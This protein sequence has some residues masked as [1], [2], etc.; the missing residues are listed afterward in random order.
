LVNRPAKAKARAGAGWTTAFDLLLLIGGLIILHIA[1]SG[2]IPSGGDG[3][4]WLALAREAQGEDVM[5]AAVV[6][7][8]VFIVIL[9]WL[10]GMLGLVNGLL[11]A[12]FIAEA[13]LVTVVYLMVSRAGRAPAIVAAALVGV[14]GYRLEAYAWGAYP[15]ILAIG[16]GLLAVWVVAR[17]VGS[18]RWSWLGL[19]GAGIVTVFATHKLV[20]GLMLMAI[21]A[22]AIHTVWL[23]RFRG[24]TWKWAGLAVLVAGVVGAFFVSSWL[25]ATAQGVEPTLNPLGLSRFENLSFAFGEA[26]IPW[27]ILTV[28]AFIGLGRR[29]WNRGAAP[30]VSASFGWVLASTVGFILLGE[31]RILIQA[32]VAIIPIAVMEIWRWWGERN[33]STG[34]RRWPTVSLGFL[35]VAVVGSVAL[36][37]MHRYDVAADWYRV[38]GQ[39]ELD[40]LAGLS[41]AADPGDLAIASRGPNGNPIGWWVQGYAGIPTYT[42]MDTAFLA[43]PDEK[44]QAEFAATLFSAVPE[45]AAVSMDEVGARFLILDRRGSDVG[46]LGDGDPVGLQQLSDGT[47]LIM[48]ASDGS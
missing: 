44:E 1:V 22:A 21:P 43:F 18:G 42:N 27:L 5:S 15:Q 20:G 29:S 41:D 38:V 35:A 25:G 26:V 10:L 3:G 24:E 45:Q 2:P 31:P 40:T 4:N 7:E 34:R 14:A 33:P 23:G 30:M 13:L 37:G 8:P 19:A 16:L 46:W 36:T 28:A 12:A 9:G 11:V 48:E 47:L 32:Q 6:Y 17:F 39:R